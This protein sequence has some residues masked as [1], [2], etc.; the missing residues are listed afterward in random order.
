MPSKQGVEKDE[1]VNF[2]MTTRKRRQRINKAKR[3][4]PYNSMAES[5]NIEDNITLTL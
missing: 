1:G 4:C 5:L 3:R 2:V